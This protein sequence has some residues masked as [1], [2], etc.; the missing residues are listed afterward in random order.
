MLVEK[1]FEVLKS[2][3]SKSLESVD[4]IASSK[5]CGDFL[6]STGS[7]RAFDRK[8]AVS[9]CNDAMV[10]VHEVLVQKVRVKKIILANC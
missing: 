8:V 10:L 9:N 2:L 7:S 3:A 6:L 5:C 1:S 4:I